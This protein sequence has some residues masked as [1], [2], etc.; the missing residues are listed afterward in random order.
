MAFR[1]ALIPWEQQ[2]QEAVDIAWDNPLLRELSAL[3]T[4]AVP[5]VEILSGQQRVGGD[6]P[7]FATYEASSAGLG[8]TTSVVSQFISVNFALATQM[9]AQSE[10]TFFCRSVITTIPGSE[11]TILE[12]NSPGG[13]GATINILS[14]GVLQGTTVRANTT[15]NSDAAYSVGQVVDVAYRCR[16]GEQTLWINGVRQSGSGTQST[17]VFQSRNEFRIRSSCA[18]TVLAG[19]A[20]RAYSDADLRSLH[21][22]PWQL[23]APRAIRVFVPAAGPSIPT[24]SAATAID[25]TS[26]SARPRVTIT[27]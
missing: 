26:T 22:N 20:N 10:F 4:G 8:Q 18:I 27:F 7:S 17:N 3:W 5:L 12:L 11:S 1:D 16:D 21:A 19:C 25:I 23:F 14:T 15:V 9:P 24:L 2:P 13:D 6:N